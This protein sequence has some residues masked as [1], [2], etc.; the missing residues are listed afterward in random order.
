MSKVVLRIAAAVSLLAAGVLLASPSAG[1][2]TL[3]QQG[4]WYKLVQ[5]PT[6][7]L[8]ASP[9]A[10]ASVPEDGLFVANDPSGAAAISAVRFTLPEA[11]EGTLTLTV[12]KDS[13]AGT[14]ALLACP[15]A[16]GW[17]PA[18]K[19][20]WES[21]PA[22]EP[23]TCTVEGV[24]DEAGTAVFAIPASFYGGQGSI[25]VIIVPGGTAPFSIAFEKPTDASYTSAGAS[26]GS[27]AF[28]PGTE[29]GSDF[30]SD[31]ATDSA[32]TSDSSGSFD[33]GSS[34]T[35]SSSFDSGSGSSGS[36]FSTSPDTADFGAE[37]PT[38]AAGAAPDISSTGTGS[39]V[40]SGGQNTAAPA[41]SSPTKNG[42]A[43]RIIAG[44]VLGLLAI[45]LFLASGAALPVL[46][47]G[48]VPASITAQAKERPRGIGRFSRPR[49]APPTGLT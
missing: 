46:T 8:P 43:K 42:T 17:A 48:A 14:P 24:V 5:G 29:V 41:A 1:A 36:S 6:S 34:S 22:F 10:P 3:Q 31:P 23:S 47:G 37:A 21:R 13:T 9:P 18:Q 32:A 26:G 16:G 12:A 7:A 38:V 49:V 2:E 11:A 19:G 39:D 4:W 28:D 20:A 45:G 27:S 35:G 15:A 25:D 40:G 30:S 33:T 44:S